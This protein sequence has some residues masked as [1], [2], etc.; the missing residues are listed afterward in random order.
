MKMIQLYIMMKPHIIGSVFDPVS[1]IAKGLLP[2]WKSD[3][4]SMVH[5]QLLQV[6]I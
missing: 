6:A 4:F 3:H 2:H 1:A 5:M